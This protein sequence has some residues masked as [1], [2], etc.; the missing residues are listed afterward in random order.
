[1]QPLASASHRSR[2]S[3]HSFAGRNLMLDLVYVAIT[4]GFF[5]LM[6]AYIRGCEALGREDTHKEGRP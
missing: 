3:I 2:G 5:A 4:L 6:L 1:M